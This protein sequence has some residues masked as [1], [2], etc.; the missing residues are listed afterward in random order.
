MN[1]YP[2]EFVQQ[3][4]PLMLVGG[5]LAPTQAQPASTPAL[6]Q[7]TDA[8]P[9]LCTQLVKLL[10]SK[11]RSTAWDP[12]SHRA[13]LL[14]SSGSGGAGSSSGAGASSAA[15]ARSGSTFRTILVPDNFRLPPRK[16][17]LQAPPSPSVARQ[18]LPDG[19]G[20][21]NG[22][23]QQS[24]V[25]PPPPASSGAGQIMRSA[26]SPLHPQS[27]LYPDGLISP[28]WVRKH[29]DVIPSIFVLFQVLPSAGSS[30]QQAA[31]SP[32]DQEQ[33][34]TQLEGADAALIKYI[35][36]LRAL[37]TARSIKLTVVLL[38]SR[39]SLSHPTLEPRLSHLRRAS[40][41]D[42]KGSLFVLTPVSEPDLHDF[43]NSLQNALAEA[44]TDYYREQGRRVRRKRGKY[45]PPVS[46]YGSPDG[47]APGSGPPVPPL[48][49][50]GWSLRSA[51]KLGTFA[52]LSGDL[53]LSLEH[54]V[55][56]Y[57]VLSSTAH[58]HNGGL[59]GDTR[60]LPPRTKRWAEAKALA[61]GLVVRI[62]R[63]W[64]L[65]GLE[66]HTFTV[67]NTSA[68]QG[69]G[70]AG[71]DGTSSGTEKTTQIQIYLPSREAWE[72]ALGVFRA[73]LKRFEELS[74]GWG[75]GVTTGEWWSWVG[76]Q[77]RLYADLVD[78][79]V[80]SYRHAPMITLSQILPEH[81]PPLPS[82]LLH[83]SILPTYSAAL[84]AATSGV[85]RAGAGQHNRND[86]VATTVSSSS[87]GTP[88]RSS[89]LPSGFNIDSSGSGPG[90]NSG[91]APL[92]LATSLALT[93]LGPTPLAPSP[94]ASKSGI[95]PATGVLPHP[96]QWYLLAAL[97]AEERWR[98]WRVR[99]EREKEAGAK[100]R[101][102]DPSTAAERKADHA[103]LVI[104]AL[105]RAYE[106][107]K[108]PVNAYS[109]GAASAATSSSS[110]SASSS[111]RSRTA[112][113]VAARMAHAYLLSGQNGLALSF[114]QR[115]LVPF[116]GNPHVNPSGSKP[117]PGR[118]E[119]IL[120]DLLMVGATAAARLE[121]EALDLESKRGSEA[122]AEA[123]EVKADDEGTSEAEAGSKKDGE[124]KADSDKGQSSTPGN[125]ASSYRNSRLRFLWE[126]LCVL[127]HPPHDG[128]HALHRIVL[129]EF[130]G[131]LSHA[132][133]LPAPKDQAADAVVLESSIAAHG[134]PFR[135]DVVF[136]DAAIEV[137]ESTRVQVR[138]LDTRSSNDESEARQPWTFDH[139]EL[140]VGPKKRV[141]AASGDGHASLTTFTIE[142]VAGEADGV[143]ELSSSVAKADLTFR[144]DRPLI[145]EG[146]VQSVQTG[147]LQVH[148]VRLFAAQSPSPCIIKI[149]PFVPDLVYAGLPARQAVWYIPSH[150]R[151][152]KL[153]HRL[154]LSEC[155]VKA[156]TYRVNLSTLTGGSAGSSAESVP[157]YLH[158]RF[159]LVVQI[160]S[161]ETGSEGLEGVLSVTCALSGFTAED[162]TDVIS[163]DDQTSDREL[164][165]VPL[166]PL[167]AGQA[168]KKLVY[169]QAN[170]IVGPRQLRISLRV[171]PSASAQPSDDSTRPEWEFADEKT[172]TVTLDVRAPFESV[173][174]LAWSQ[175]QPTTSESAGKFLSA[176][177]EVFVHPDG[178][179]NG[180]IARL[181]AELGLLGKEAI[182]VEKA[183]IHLNNE[184]VRTYGNVT[185]PRTRADWTED[186]AGEWAEGDRCVGHVKVEVARDSNDGD[187]SSISPDAPGA[188]YIEVQWRRV[189]HPSGATEEGS[190]I[191]ARTLIPLPALIPPPA[192]TVS[193]VLHF[194]SF[195]RLGQPFV[196]RATIKNEQAFRTA[197]V[198]L[199]VES[200]DIFVFA[201]PRRLTVPA[202]LPRSER[203]VVWR[204][205]A[206]QTGWVDL[207]AVRAEDARARSAAEYEAS[208]SAGQFGIDEAGLTSARPIP[209]RSG[210]PVPVY[211][212]R[213]LG[214]AP[215]IHA[216]PG[217]SATGT[218]A[219]GD[220]L[221]QEELRAAMG[222]PPPPTSSSSTLGRGSAIAASGVGPAPP[223]VVL[224]E[225]R[226]LVGS[227]EGVRLGTIRPPGQ[228]MILVLP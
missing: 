23:A 149:R 184:T 194:P 159:P 54:Y 170:S 11:G 138:V 97:C 156:R 63:G 224:A 203:K 155:S 126:A 202:L 78:S 150:H 40:G 20:S 80:R 152:I 213:R 41:L 83:P 7:P 117:A 88:T 144:S 48:T 142:H 12:N 188:G 38:T 147:S 17:R 42:S 112:S 87:T 181:T 9:Q 105:T 141:K 169:F 67:P 113:Y 206:R 75:M 52:E 110:S 219:V 22:A 200:S 212:G 165:Q 32:S 99:E 115:I 114:A 131:L 111:V 77:Y 24:A 163:C 222:N 50:E 214:A 179:P 162:G 82:N 81:C 182:V 198:R 227:K 51:Y 106:C 176:E 135:V 91:P 171:R 103:G 133:P 127:S 107:F 39:A 69:G 211:D 1:A 62:A 210:G 70:E 5:L 130:Q 21:A 146:L 8:F 139:L 72:R 92:S 215:V 46:A 221:V 199:E 192:P 158:E 128:R 27:P 134:A 173:F 36:N 137:G 3:H 84:A 100:V 189:N 86:S 177:D 31:A 44:S 124:S 168:L 197:N 183:F 79:I 216:G 6:T 61:D 45:P 26:L 172:E 157:V 164:V 166:G 47:S 74:N 218:G 2:A 59:L 76:K 4:H 116:R 143:V 64:L 89:T 226:G 53:S 145:L 15:G 193:I 25:P 18:P 13:N 185:E 101:E 121:E 153:D 175:E 190:K 136:W 37:L 109:L 98:R 58:P 125:S 10:S 71:A 95:A 209:E 217:I 102:D 65:L 225:Q 123:K 160:E 56:A 16:V 187:V 19:P 132:T 119:G 68:E 120:L 122:K 223:S 14:G 33:Q 207:P 208:T 29:R 60:V 90:T 96:G 57:D 191:L 118:S 93:L 196:L 178:S 201:G 167:R 108:R 94:L 204:L 174:S 35:S 129:E 66:A 205:M 151:F 148:E 180:A 104:E 228:C 220:N 43:I 161:Q 186:F 34:Q 140:D 28:L 154:V 55:N 73:H 49:K 195:T 85:S 30:E